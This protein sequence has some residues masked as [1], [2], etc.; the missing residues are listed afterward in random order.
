M[1][2]LNED[3]KCGDGN[4]SLRS[5]RGRMRSEICIGELVISMKMAFK[6]MRLD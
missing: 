6:V 2:Y 5:S 4:M 3:V 1:R